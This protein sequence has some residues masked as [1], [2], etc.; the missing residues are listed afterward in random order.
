MLASLSA[1][2][3]FL[4]TCGIE[5]R[6]RLHAAFADGPTTIKNVAHIR[7]QETDRIRAVVTELHRIGVR[8][9]EHADGLTIHPSQPHA[10]RIDTYNDHRIAMSFALAGLRIP[11]I[12]ILNPGCTVKTYPTFFA[13]LRSLAAD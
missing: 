10:A 7:K 6:Q 3:E 1:R 11:G 5:L 9:E 4:D 13:D 12:V 2:A 8:T